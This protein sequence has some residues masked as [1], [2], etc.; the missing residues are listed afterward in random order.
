VFTF[1]LQ[2]RRNEWG[3]FVVVAYKDGI[4]YPDADYHTDDWRD[5][6]DTKDAMFIHEQN[7]RELLLTN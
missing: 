4:R 5:A 6:L 2:R 1:T 7:R 3:E